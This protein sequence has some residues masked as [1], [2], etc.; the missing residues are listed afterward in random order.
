L[1]NIQ[2]PADFNRESNRLRFSSEVSPQTVPLK[3]FP[4][5]VYTNGPF[6]VI[7]T[8][9]VGFDHPFGLSWITD[10]P[11]RNGDHGR[12]VFPRWYEPQIRTSM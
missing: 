2:K 11:L 8:C 6:F 10:R 1:K 3:G 12:I 5:W 9:I 7:F 4:T